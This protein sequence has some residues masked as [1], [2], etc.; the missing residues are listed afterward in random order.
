VWK[1]EQL[2]KNGAAENFFCILLRTRLTTQG[3]GLGESMYP[4]QCEKCLIQCCGPHHFDADPDADTDP[5][6]HFDADPDPACHS[7]ADA[8]PDPSFQIKAQNLE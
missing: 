7:D 2:S 6:F 5:T 3:T 8:D 4:A 1:K